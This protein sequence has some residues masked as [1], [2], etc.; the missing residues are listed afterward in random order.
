[1]LRIFHSFPLFFA[2]LF[3]CFPLLLR[4]PYFSRL[5]KA[6]HCRSP[7][8]SIADRL[9]FFGLPLGGAAGCS[10]E[11][12]NVFDR[13]PNAAILSRRMVRDRAKDELDRANRKG[14][15]N[16]GLVARDNPGVT[17]P[18]TGG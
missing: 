9:L 18:I 17:P 6:L 2:L 15:G 14:T 13:A 5:Y 11:A 16:P 10:G 3:H 8:F 1:M 12:R 7:R 4:R